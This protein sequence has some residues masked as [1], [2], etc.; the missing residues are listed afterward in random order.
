MNNTHHLS[1]ETLTAL[2]RASTAING[3]MNL[4]ET[5]SAIAA[6]A[7]EVLRAEASSV[8]MLDEARGKQAIRAAAGASSQR[9]LGLEYGAGLGLSGKALEI[10]KSVVVADARREADHYQEIDTRA[11]FE[12]RSL[13]AS[14][15]IHKGRHFGVVEVINPLDRPAFDEKDGNVAEIFANLAAI[16]VANAHLRQRLRRDNR[17]LRQVA[18]R[19]GELIGSGAAIQAVRTLIDRVAPSDATVL[20]LGETG[21]GKEL[22]ARMVHR[23]SDRSRRPFVPV[24]CAAL[25]A[26]LFESELF[27]HEAGA[28]TGAVARKI[29][30]FELADGGTI[31][32]DE[33]AEVEPDIQV[34]L[35]RVLEDREIVRV[36]GMSPVGVNVRVI[37]ATNRNLTEEIRE[38][39]FREDLYYRLNVFPIEI[40]PL[41]Q[42]REDIPALVE[43][44]LERLAAELKVSRPTASPDALAALTA[45]DFPG[46]VRELRNL[47]ERACLLCLT[48]GSASARAATLR[49]EHLPPEIVARSGPATTDSALEAGERGMILSALKEHNWNQSAAARALNITRDSMR[50]RIRKYRLRRGPDA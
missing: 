31:F 2:L 44:L 6:S 37:A 30:R 19:P 14:P 3:A 7:A 22:A 48:P 40:P 12:T 24:N 36:G 35:L 49:P 13:I 28:F 32:L 21:V 8:I 39:R 38:G 33:I 20:L 34:K 17:H 42:R 50:Y 1:S 23:D 16:A 15:L 45:Y 4:D 29:G 26:A 47:L 41:R 43:S 27:G 18:G 11:D 46:N 10:G 25:S 5:L 9:V